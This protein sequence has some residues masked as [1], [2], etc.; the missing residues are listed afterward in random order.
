[1]KDEIL[2][3][4]SDIS[5]YDADAIKESDFFEEDLGF[6]S[7]MLMDLYRTLINQFSEITDQTFPKEK[8]KN[9]IKISDLFSVLNIGEAKNNIQ[10]SVF[11]EFE[12]IVSFNEY[13]ETMKNKVP[14]FREN[15]GIPTNTI[16]INNKELINFSTYNYL[17]LNGST[18]VSEF[19]KS[20]I[21][22]FGTSVSGSRLLSGEI[23]LHNQLEAKISNF[24]GVEDTLVQV[25]GHSTNINIITQLVSSED[26]ILHDSLAHNS[27]IQGALFSGA[28][29][30]P[31]KHN[32]MSSLEKELRLLSKKYRR[33]L[34][35]VEGVYSMDGDICNLPELIRIKKEYNAILMV[36]EA[37]S[38]G[39]IGKNGRGVTS[40][41]DVE[42]NDVDILMG[43]LS[44]SVNSCGGYIAGN[45]KVINYMKY[46]LGGFV[47]SCGMTPANAA[48]ALK[49]FEL[50]ETKEELFQKL[51]NNCQFFLTELNKLGFDTGLSEGTAVI[52]IIIGDSE[53]ALTLSESL[54]KN[55]INAMPIVYPA[56]KE[57]EARLRFFMSAAHTKKELEKTIDVLSSIK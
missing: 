4:I 35:V 28:K 26:L 14:Y 5:G 39:T 48:A 20:A 44:K 22:K 21:D 43:T 27:I 56:V 54:Y 32:D 19:A 45:S 40:Y 13:Y 18:E 42:P 2:E 31:F 25:G 10:T 9:D 15:Q 7:I 50:F 41:F 24:L 12:E 37:H 16:S 46:N 34:I 36:D 11:D 6:D 23:E 1:M 57:H 49:S 3:I 47:F 52:P 17:G 8:L 51:D 33:V 55:G 53:R 30:K 29:R 38:L